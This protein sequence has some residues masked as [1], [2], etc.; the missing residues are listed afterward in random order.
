MFEGKIRFASLTAIALLAWIALS[1]VRSPVIGQEPVKA[2]D[3]GARIKVLQ[4]EWLASVRAAAKLD[5]AR[6]K[7]GQASPDEMLASTRMLSEAELDVCKSDKERA[8]V[9]ENIVGTARDTERLAE[10]LARTGQGRESV[11]LKAKAERLRF[12]IA[13]ERAKSKAATEPTDGGANLDSYRRQLALAEKQAAIKQAAVKVAEAQRAKAQA[14]VAAVKSQVAQA[15]AAESY[16][17]TQFQRFSDLFKTNAIEERLLDENRAKL[18]AA[19]S[20]RSAV[21]AQI[22]EAE[23]QAAIEQARVAQAELECE[24]AQLRVEQLNAR[25]QP[26]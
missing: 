9:L 18:E 26:R 16:A 20:K 1:T 7:S 22:A 12:E 2:P 10:A 17:D 4:K 3:Q 14:S 25:L 11:A 15:K 24:E 8:A 21:E 6:V 19:R 5:A 13:L 23:S